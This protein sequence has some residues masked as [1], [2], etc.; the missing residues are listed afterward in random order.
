[1]G[2][3]T[4]PAFPRVAGSVSTV[5]PDLSV[6]SVV[7]L[8]VAPIAG[9]VHLTWSNPSDPDVV[10]IN[11]YQIDP[12]GGRV[13]VGTHSPAT[14]EADVFAGDLLTKYSYFV[15][16]VDASG[17]R[18]ASNKGNTTYAL[19]RHAAIR[20]W[21]RDAGFH[22]ANISKPEIYIE[23]LGEPGLADLTA[24]YWFQQG[25][26]GS[27]AVVHEDYSTPASAPA[28]R[29]V[30]VD[31]SLG[32][33]DLRFSGSLP[34]GS[35][36]GLGASGPERVGLHY[37]DWRL[38]NKSGDFSAQNLSSRF[39]VTD[40]IPVM[41]NT[42][43]GPV[44]IYGRGVDE[45]PKALPQDI[46]LNVICRD[47]GSVSQALPICTVR[48]LGRTIR[49]FHVRYYFTTSRAPAMSVYSAGDASLT[50]PIQ[51]APSMYYVDAFF[52]S[53][54]SEGQ[55]TRE[56]RFG[57]YNADWS[58]WT[59]ND[60]FSA[61]GM[62]STAASTTLMPVLDADSYLMH[63]SMP[64]IAPI[65]PAN[66]CGV[67]Y[68]GSVQPT[69]TTNDWPDAPASLSWGQGFNDPEYVVQ[70]QKNYADD[71]SNV[72]SLPTGAYTR[73]SLKLKRMSGSPTAIR[74]H[75]VDIAGV[76]S[77]PRDIAL[78]GSIQDIALTS[79]Q[80]TVPAGFQS[81]KIAGLGITLP[82]MAAWSWAT[83][84][85]DDVKAACD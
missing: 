77:Q 10:A 82:N 50:G 70:G 19:S 69:W 9:G 20:V 46:R 12:S 73:F 40:R 13:L 24:Q 76:A 54:L 38:Y 42:A 31:A 84:L 51:V 61:Q 79:Q 28:L 30:D 83:L 5:V 34:I 59:R 43:S 14:V 66:T 3:G 6:A 85:L 78:T 7:G 27:S 68:D 41:L 80:F 65:P 62:G 36:T 44:Q 63:G 72:L 26:A 35:S 22:E 67:E 74:L 25:L 52:P 60:D 32:H 2:S 23:N 17:N 29:A 37:P 64:L 18:S 49:A 21:A 75:L 16:T 55:E 1:V 48:N 47:G 53:P 11:V 39:Q 56:F 15:E 57:V 33:L 8:A 71:W 58:T 4:I 45:I 81:S